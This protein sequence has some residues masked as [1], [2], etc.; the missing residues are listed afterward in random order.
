[1]TVVMFRMPYKQQV[2]V[3]MFRM[4]YKQQVTVVMFRMPYKQQVEEQSE[5]IRSLTAE[6]DSLKIEVNHSKV[7]NYLLQ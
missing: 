5:R 4:P 6:R 1:V 7:F 3:V 2:T